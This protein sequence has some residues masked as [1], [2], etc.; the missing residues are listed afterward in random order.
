M[1]L[2]TT[3]FDG[4]IDLAPAWESLPVGNV[5]L[6]VKSEK[7]ESKRFF[8]K[9]AMFR[10]GAYG[11]ARCGYGESAAKCFRYLIDMPALRYLAEKGEPDP[12]YELNCYPSKMMSA[13]ARGFARHAEKCPQDAE[14]ALHVAKSAAD[15]LISAS[16]KDGSALPGTP[17]TYMGDRLTAKANAGLVMTSYPCAAASAYITLGRRTGE[18]KYI[19]APLTAIIMEA[20]N[21][22]S[23]ADFRMFVHSSVQTVARTV[24]VLRQNGRYAPPPGQCAYITHLGLKYRD[25]P[26]DKIDAELPSGI[27]SAHDGFETTFC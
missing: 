21:G 20:T 13:V 19:A 2:A 16:G 9:K 11:K 6:A 14:R 26:S 27:R 22:D 7:G 17:P 8:W 1:S 10:E 15:W 3:A 5:Q 25:W 23:D 4:V 12:D 24:E 18:A